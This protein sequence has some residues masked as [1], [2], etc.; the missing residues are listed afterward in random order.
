MYCPKCKAENFSKDGTVNG[1]SQYSCAVCG[2]NVTI[3]VVP[4]S[5]NADKKREVLILYFAG[6]DIDDIVL[7]SR[8]EQEVVIR[9]I[10]EVT[11]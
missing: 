6:Y 1:R 10:N 7:L 4:K 9:L 3:P 2:F 11:L 8:L 5:E